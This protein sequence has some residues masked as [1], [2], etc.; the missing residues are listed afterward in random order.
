MGAGAKTELI[1]IERE[2]R[3]RRADAGYDEGWAS[4]GQVWA[5]VT[6][7][8]GSESEQRGALRSVRRYRFTCATEALEEM[9]VTPADRVIWNGEAFNV[10]E[11]PRRVIGQPDTDLYAESGVT[12]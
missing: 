8:G 10:R 9:A 1:T 3:T 6:Y 12:Q 7:A 11:C 2:T 5:A 4:V